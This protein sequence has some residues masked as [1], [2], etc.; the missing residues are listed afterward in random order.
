MTDAPP[1]NFAAP[2]EVSRPRGPVHLVARH[3]HPDGA[4]EVYLHLAAVEDLLA[5]TSLADR[6]ERA[7]LMAGEW[8]RDAR[9][10][11]VLVRRALPATQAPADRTSVTF[12]PA[13]WEE[14]WTALERECP[15]L[16]VVGWW[17]THP[18]LG[19]FLSEPDRFIH[20][21]FFAESFHLAL[22][23]DP[24]AFAWGIFCWEGE[25][26]RAAGGLYLY[27][28]REGDYPHLRETL[29][30]IAPAGIIQVEFED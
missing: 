30:E 3:G 11:F 4:L 19:I 5:A 7:G 28:E 27:A 16:A 15:G 13:A 2:P 10:P 22:V 21:N 1:D 9:G 29:R 14:L 26:L 20:R 8:G 18:G 25:E 17:H 6:Q 12:T 24:L 23:Y